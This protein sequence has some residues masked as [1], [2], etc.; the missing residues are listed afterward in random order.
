MSHFFPLVARWGVRY[1][2]FSKNKKEEIST[3]ITLFQYFVIVMDKNISYYKNTK[4]FENLFLNNLTPL[5]SRKTAL[6]SINKLVTKFTKR[7]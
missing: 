6:R 5:D 2:G 3:C 4:A 7:E 1:F